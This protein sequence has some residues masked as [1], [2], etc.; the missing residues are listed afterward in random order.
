[1]PENQFI[2]YDDSHS[3]RSLDANDLADAL[4]I[5]QWNFVVQVTNTGFSTFTIALHLIENGSDRILGQVTAGASDI[6]GSG[7]PIE[8][9]RQFRLLALLSPV[10]TS[11]S[12]PLRESAMLRLY[13]KLQS[14]S[15]SSVIVD[16][17]F[18]KRHEGID[19][20]SAQVVRDLKAPPGGS[21]G[22]GTLFDLISSDDHKRIVRISFH[23]G[24]L[25]SSKRN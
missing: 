14:G 10:D 23:Q 15:R 19:Y 25:G 7:K 4:G 16:N 18:R 3:Y 5:M 6:D 13:A 24:W 1:M 20:G 11:G 8:G 2:A 17:P 21:R 22:F 12:D 9:P